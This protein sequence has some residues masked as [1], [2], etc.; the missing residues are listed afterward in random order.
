MPVP[1]VPA[2]TDFGGLPGGQ[3]VEAYRLSNPLGMSVAVLTY[4]CIV[5]TI[6]VS[7]ARGEG[8]NVALRFAWLEDYL[9]R[10]PYFGAHSPTSSQPS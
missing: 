4:G 3:K 9:V 1:A 8:R 2:A 7:D 5:Q 10:S 6:E